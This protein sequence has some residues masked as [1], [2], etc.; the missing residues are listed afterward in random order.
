MNDVKGHVW[1]C[2]VP[3]REVQK[4]NEKYIVSNLRN[5]GENVELRIISEFQPMNEAK[6]AEAT[7]EDAY[8]YQMGKTPASIGGEQEISISGGCTLHL[9][10]VLRGCAGIW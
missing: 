7:L 6:Y 1:Q 10:N 5:S 3:E 4:I 9:I 8:L 2:V